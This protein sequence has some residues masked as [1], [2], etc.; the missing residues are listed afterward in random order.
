M[1]ADCFRLFAVCFACCALFVGC[2]SPADPEAVAVVRRNLQ[3]MELLDAPALLDTMHWESPARVSLLDGL[4]QLRP[5][6]LQ[7]E[8]ESIQWRGSKGDRAGVEV[9]QVIHSANPESGYRA[10]KVR[11]RYLL[12][13]QGEEWKIWNIEILDISYLSK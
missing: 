7:Y 1:K 9:R 8:T 13:K 6:A 10:N 2:E 12:K 4:D 11:G 3:A 5:F